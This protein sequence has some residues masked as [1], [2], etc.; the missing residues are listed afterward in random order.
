MTKMKIAIIFVDDTI[1]YSFGPNVHI[2]MTHLQGALGFAIPCYTSNHLGIN[3][4]KS[5]MKL[6]GQ[7]SKVQNHVNLTINN[8]PVEQ[9][10]SNNY[11][12]IHLNDYLSWD[13]PWDKLCRNIAG[14]ISVLRSIR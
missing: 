13:G 3:A 7:K 8:V 12:G 14:K 5:A 6:V 4:E 2:A 9:V 10:N 1:I 11:L